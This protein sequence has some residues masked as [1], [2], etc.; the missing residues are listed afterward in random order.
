MSEKEF[1]DFLTAGFFSPR[2]I[3][4][5]EMIDAMLLAPVK[6]IIGGGPK[7]ITSLEAILERLWTK[8]IAGKRRR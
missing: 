8:A 1:I 6:I 7:Q 3:G 5:V 4:I 2:S